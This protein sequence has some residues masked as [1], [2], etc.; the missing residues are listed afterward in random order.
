MRVA[1]DVLVRFQAALSLRVLSTSEPS[2]CVIDGF[3]AALSL[4]VL[5]TRT[6][7]AS[8]RANCFKQHYR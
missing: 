4:R 5:S 8:L 6:M 7:L 3:Q 1:C 2:V